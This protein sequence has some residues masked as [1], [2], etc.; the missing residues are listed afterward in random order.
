MYH[1]TFPIHLCR[2]HI[3]FD[4]LFSSFLVLIL[5]KE[6]VRN[7]FIAQETEAKYCVFVCMYVYDYLDW[8]KPYSLKKLVDSCPAVKIYI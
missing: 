4:R 5:M 1:E 3:K 8:I 7:V 2:I 6:I